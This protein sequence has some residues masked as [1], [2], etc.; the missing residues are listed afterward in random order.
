MS[1][2]LT[3]GQAFDL[4]CETLSRLP[5]NADKESVVSLLM[6]RYPPNNIRKLVARVGGNATTH[7]QPVAAPAVQETKTTKSAKGKAS[8]KKGS[9]AA[10]LEWANDPRFKALKEGKK[11]AAAVL[12]KAKKDNG[13]TDLAVEDH[14]VV[15]FNEAATLVSN[16]RP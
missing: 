1:A 15:A 13:G 14:R 16:F 4:I 11:A 10:P 6:T 7:Q 8:K 9:I 3:Q 12:A 5:T 2:K